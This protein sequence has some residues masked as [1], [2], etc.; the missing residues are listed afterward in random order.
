MACGEDQN[1]SQAEQREIT[2]A[3]KDSV[4]ASKAEKR[5]YL[6][7]R[8]V[9]S[10]SHFIYHNLPFLSVFSIADLVDMSDWTHPRPFAVTP[11][12]FGQ[13]KK[14]SIDYI[15]CDSND[16]AILCIEFDGLQEG[17]S[18]GTDY[19]PSENVTAQSPWRRHILELKL[20][21]AHG[22]LFPFFVVGSKQFAAIDPTLQLTI[23]DGIVGEVLTL[24]ATGDR[25]ARGFDPKEMS[26]SQDGFQR[27]SESA[28]RDVIQDWLIGVEVNTKLGHN[29]IARE[30]AILDHELSI[31][32]FKVQ[33]LE[34]PS[35]NFTADLETRAQQFRGAIL[36][37]SRVTLNT[38]D[39]GDVSADA[40]LPNFKSPGFSPHGLTEEIAALIALTR[41]KRLRRGSG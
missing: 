7:L 32:S 37:G 39:H 13:L 31:T 5:N 33:P 16:I 21:V 20:R 9:W 38:E 36:F 6:K 40:W 27:L 18:V 17:F 19:Y 30:R 25:I 12:E 41:L 1:S 11:S 28:Q 35:P 14:T 29:P 3:I 23:A 8:R 4:F 22:S 10:P 15:L 26:Y 34:Y 24:R 2:V